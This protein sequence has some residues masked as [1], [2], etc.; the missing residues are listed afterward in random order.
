MKGLLERVVR[1]EALAGEEAEGFFLQVAEGKVEPAVLA[2]F[3][4]AVR[5][6]GERAE[7]LEALARVMMGKALKVFPR[8]RPLLDVVGTGGDGHS[9]LNLST[10]SA[11]VVASLG[12]PVAKHGNRAVSGRCGSA[13]LLE[14]LGLRV[15]APR[16]RVV[17]SIDEVG[18]GFL[19]A[20]LYHPA[21]AHA[22]PVRKALGIR[23]LFNFLGPLINPADPDY[24]LIGAPTPEGARVMAGALYGLGKRALVV[25]GREGLDEPSPQGETLLLEVGPEGIREGVLTPGDFGLEPVPLEAIRVRGKDEAVER[26]KGILQGADDP[27]LPAVLMEAALALKLVGMTRELSEGV[28]LAREALREGRAWEV[29]ERSKGFLDG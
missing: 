14:A 24:L 22:A 11:L 27:G 15:D 23:T 20:P 12:I 25:H 7:E 16:E 1:G 2:G 13:D 17:R 8:R 26:A 5:M 3:L 19:L 28:R 6:R 9:T 21:L 18:F 4:V 29:L 10:L